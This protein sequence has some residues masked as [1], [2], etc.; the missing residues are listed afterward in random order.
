MAVIGSLSVKLG[1]VTVEW[2]QATAKA[3]AQA[4]DLQGAFKNLTSELSV[5]SQHFKTL[6]GVTSVGA[7]GFTALFASTAAYA[8]E[9]KDLAEGF[10]I[11]ISKVLQFRDA[12]QT[13]GGKA[14]SAAKMLST[15]FGKMEEGKKGSEPIIETF[16]KLG[17]SFE[18]LQTIKPEDALN[19]VF[20]GLKNIG[21]TTERIKLLRE[22]MGKG[23]VGLGVAELA[24]KINQSTASFKKHEDGLKR[25]GDLSDNLKSSMDNLKIAF[26]DLVSPFIGEGKASVEKFKVALLAIASVAVVNQ[27][28][29]IVGLF[30]ALN[31]AMATG[32]KIAGT[33]AALSG[34]KGIALVGGAVAAYAVLNKILED[35]EEKIAQLE[36]DKKS[37]QAKLGRGIDATVIRNIARI[38]KEIALLQTKIPDRGNKE[39]LP[40]AT[41]EDEEG[42]D[43]A[44]ASRD[45]D[46][47]R[48]K[49][50]AALAL[51]K[52]MDRENQLKIEGLTTD[53]WALEIK[54][55]DI[56]FEK[57]KAKI[58]AEYATDRVA[59]KDSVE[60]EAVAGE[61]AAIAL[62]TA[63][64]KA[65]GAKNFAAASRDKEIEDLKRQTKLQEELFEF[66]KKTFDLRLLAVTTGDYEIQAKTILLEKEKAIAQVI[67]DK[68][69][70]L[71]PTGQSAAAI[72]AI[73]VD[74]RS[75]IARIEID[76]A[77]RD[78][79]RIANKEKE[80]RILDAQSVT[81]ARLHEFDMA[82]IALEDKRIYLTDLEYKK[83]SELLE[84]NRRLLEL[85]Q[86]R[87]AVTDRYGA[88]ERA[89]KER[90]RIDEA[91]AREKELSAA[92][93]I[94]LE[95]EATRQRSFVEGWD[96]AF[97]QYSTNALNAFK[98]GEEA[99]AALTSNMER[100]LDQFVSTG[101]LSFK[102]LASSIIKDLIRI[103]MR[104]QMTSMFGGLKELFSGGN[105]SL[106][107][108]IGSAGGGANFAS[109]IAGGYMADGGPVAANTPYMVGERGP[110]L[111]IPKGAGT[112]IPNNQ[113]AGA[114]SGPQITYNGPYIANMQAID[115][116]SATQFLARN[117]LSVY[118]A[119]Q[120]A[121]RSLP[122]SR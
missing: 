119:N 49:N 93:N 62:N 87:L 116:Q 19:K 43:V 85:E 66:E 110:E 114:M 53:K 3:K 37:E 7:I 102:D 38:E 47:A 82:K 81:S 109:V 80:F 9:V 1:L 117:K 10:D 36:L 94:S 46:A 65:E 35:P 105:S 24:D 101:K 34:A 5:L 51:L 115:T 72:A 6:G 70:K 83:Q 11:T 92:R 75:K 78:V 106:A 96:Y 60:L 68:N 15:L 29:K 120:S 31:K 17:I 111:I 8:N 108:D 57:E 73:E 45:S 95:N 55:A 39:L 79:L 25:F 97:R 121:A 27:L 14:E 63:Y 104:A 50:A 54:K 13:S 76:A 99:F 4:K 71:R 42:K 20:I 64:K 48:A 113:L 2:D 33:M 74:A 40:D 21:S 88:G 52:I 122:T 22:L 56:E 44:K 30:I 58:L 98:S 89:D 100:A 90:A 23:G 41:K 16:R 26:S 32:A 84:L 28:T 12:L 103:Q 91:I 18:E 67:A 77:A 118:A 59:A 61:K 107:A 112:V 69:E 86:E